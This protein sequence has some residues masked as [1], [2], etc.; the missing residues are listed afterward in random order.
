M[1]LGDQSDTE[2]VTSL[3]PSESIPAQ[4]IDRSAAISAIMKPGSEKT[5]LPPQDYFF[6]FRTGNAHSDFREQLN[7]MRKQ[8]TLCDVALVCGGSYLSVHRL[9]LAVGCPFLKDQLS[10][11]SDEE[12]TLH[13]DNFDA[14]LLACLLDFMYT[15]KFQA[16]KYLDVSKLQ[17]VNILA[18]QL[19]LCEV[20]VCSEEVLKQ[21]LAP[22]NFV[23]LWDM[24]DS[25]ANRCMRKEVVTYIVDNLDSLWIS[26]DLMAL[27]EDRMLHLLAATYANKEVQQ[28]VV[29]RMLVS[30]LK[31]NLA[32]RKSSI[33]ALIPFIRMPEVSEAYARYLLQFEPFVQE[34]FRFKEELNRNVVYHSLHHSSPTNHSKANN[35]VIVVDCQDGMT[36]ATWSKKK[37]SSECGTAVTS[38]KSRNAKRVS[39]KVALDV[40]SDH[41]DLDSRSEPWESSLTSSYASSDKVTNAFKPLASVPRTM[42]IGTQMIIADG[43]SSPSSTA[44]VVIGVNPTNCRLSLLAYDLVKSKWDSMCELGITSAPKETIIVHKALVCVVGGEDESRKDKIRSVFVSNVQNKVLRRLPDLHIP[45]SSPCLFMMGSILYVVGGEGRYTDA[46]SQVEYIDI[47]EEPPIWRNW[48]PMRHRRKGNCLACYIQGK[49]VVV[50]GGSN[51]CEYIQ[52]DHKEWKELPPLPE[53]F[54]QMAPIL[55]TL[56]GT[57][58]VFNYYRPTKLYALDIMNQCWRPELIK[59]VPP[60]WVLSATKIMNLNVASTR[61]ILPD[62]YFESLSAALDGLRRSQILTDI[63]LV[64]KD[65]D[66]FAL[67]RVVL[68]IG[69]PYFRKILTE[70]NVGNQSSVAL[71][72][73]I[74]PDSMNAVID[75][76]YSGHTTLPDKLGNTRQLLLASKILEMENFFTYLTNLLSNSITTEN[77]SVMWDLADEFDNESLSNVVI[78]Y[79]SRDLQYFSLQKQFLNLDVSRIKK[80]LCI[81]CQE[82]RA[83]KSALITIFKWTGADISSRIVQME[84]QLLPFI[85]FAFIPKIDL[86]NFL[87]TELC[88]EVSKKLWKC[89]A[90]TL[91]SRGTTVSGYQPESGDLV[92]FTNDEKDLVEAINTPTSDKNNSGRVL[93]V[94]VQELKFHE[95]VRFPLTQLANAGIF[96]HAAANKLMRAKTPRRKVWS[97]PLRILVEGNEET[98]SIRQ[99]TSILIMGWKKNGEAATHCFSLQTNIW[100]SA[101]N[102]EEVLANNAAWALHGN[103][104]YLAG[105][106]DSKETVLRS[107]VIYNVEQNSFHA[108]GRM[109]T[110]RSS[111]NAAVLS[112]HVYVVGGLGHH[113]KPLNHVE[114]YD[115]LLDRWEVVEILPYSGWDIGVATCDGKL[116]TL[117]GC[118]YVD[119]DLCNNGWS[120]G[121]HAYDP[122]V[123]QWTSIGTLPDDFSNTVPVVASIN[124]KIYAISYY[125]PT[126]MW[127]LDLGSKKWQRLHITV[128][129]NPCVL[130]RSLAIL[131]HDNRLWVLD[132]CGKMLV[133][134]LQ[135]NTWEREYPFSRTITFPLYCAIVN[136][137]V[138][139]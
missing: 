28:N 108:G 67:H 59:G 14:E 38:I 17:E 107:T 70:G 82:I 27:S 86:E 46:L 43:G 19:G 136:L 56:H 51:K 58:V 130:R 53:E 55:V 47:S 48:P 21:C 109:N 44:L 33:D 106:I 96:K 45:R 23:H 88:V 116:W 26:S 9:V 112:W 20:D 90:E 35:A 83:T 104:L 1:T 10:T 72:P 131:P 111:S 11:L 132:Y 84:E 97:A 24:A 32:E 137:S 41:V 12:L 95:T 76:L 7:L 126:I 117:G 115:I 29:L 94:D 73:S 122:E 15:G 68:V 121:C 119:N 91:Y 4:Q 110:A 39:K 63:V 78:S 74:S 40:L 81:P 123:N 135:T 114:R 64:S 71:P 6:K 30:W 37:C 133:F 92:P 61:N 129:C 98:T 22:K 49:V 57:A 127:S 105:G 124:R 93:V 66:T 36:S 50:G 100:T 42:M 69:C 25:M 128:G 54:A 138:R 79:V 113:R 101:M 2:E 125:A 85:K 13:L 103:M 16:F 118:C 8:S 99:D 75:Y 18:K 77:F 65:G 52:P 139:E 102:L 60:L 87:A 5:A 34:C 62:F 89:I 120:L 3:S 31:T 80:I 134:N